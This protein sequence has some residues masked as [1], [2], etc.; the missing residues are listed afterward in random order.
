M[1]AEQK[2]CGPPTLVAAAQ[3]ADVVA[4]DVH[5]RAT[6]PFVRVDVGAAHRVRGERPGDPAGVLAAGGEQV[7][8]LHDR[9]GEISHQIAVKLISWA[10]FYSTRFPS[11]WSRSL[12]S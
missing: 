12:P 4:A 10:P 7:A 8:P 11:S 2:R 5:A 6:H 9:P 1:R 3:V